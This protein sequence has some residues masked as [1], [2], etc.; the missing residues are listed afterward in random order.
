MAWIELHITTTVDYANQMG[1][2]LLLLGAEAVTMH[3][4]GDQPIYEPALNATPL[5]QKTRVVGLFDKEHAMEPIIHYLETQQSNKLIDHFY[6]QPLDDQ[7]W[8]RSCLTDFKPL[9]FGQRLWI[10]PSWL[11]P[12]EPHAVNI[13]LDPGLAFGTGTH[14]TTAL[15]LT[16]LDAHIQPGQTVIDYGCGSGILALAALKLGAKHVIAID[17]DPQALTATRSNAD[18]NAITPSQLETY[19]PDDIHPQPADML[20]ANILAQPL[21]ELAPL[22]AT[23]LKPNG[24][25]LLSGIL[26]EQADEVITRYLPWFSMQAPAYQQEWVRLTGTRNPY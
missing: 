22:F 5:W 17:H 8:E 24:Q 19:L 13:I 4:A 1:D 25:L 21:I 23:L 2:Q 7:D 18:R 15:C 16:W 6:L 11:T 9:R 12:P 14:P 20:I 3:D 26:A 10:C